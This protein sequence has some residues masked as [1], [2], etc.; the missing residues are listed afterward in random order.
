MQRQNDT[1]LQQFLEG[2]EKKQYAEIILFLNKRIEEDPQ[3]SDNYHYRGLVYLF[4]GNTEKAM[5]DLYQAISLSPQDAALRVSLGDLFNYENMREEALEE[6][7][8]AIQINPD[9][10]QA[11]VARAGLH[12]Q[13]KDP[14]ALDDLNEALKRNPNDAWAYHARG[15]YYL[16]MDEYEKACQD[17]TNALAFDKSNPDF[18]Q[19]MADAHY[20][21]H[22]IR[23]SLYR[24]HDVMEI[25][26][27][28]FSRYLWQGN[29]LF[30][31]G[32]FEKSKQSFKQIK[33]LETAKDQYICGMSY[34]DRAKIW[35]TLPEI[36]FLPKYDELFMQYGASYPLEILKLVSVRKKLFKAKDCFEKALQL[37]PTPSQTLFI[38][39]NL[40]G[41]NV[42]TSRIT[43]L[44][45]PHFDITQQ[46]KKWEAALQES[47]EAIELDSNFLPAYIMRCEIYKLKKDEN[48]VHQEEEL[49]QKLSKN[50]DKYDKQI[51]AKSLQPE[52]QRSSLLRFNFLSEQKN[53]SEPIRRVSENDPSNERNHRM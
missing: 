53:I 48:A 29:M 11:Y 30:A 16:M 27:D 28:N 42:M 40:S 43:S 45:D 14:Q 24:I 21:K 20:K 9:F 47:N 22:E 46:Q 37:G 15:Y 36:V 41:I 34:F 2:V 25:D 12:T 10:S 50:L 32:I 4:Q 3:D 39:Q 17:F 23:K 8:H 49:I 51:F 31:C 13:F 7:N 6:Y 52:N 1:P 33:P 5:A 44:I 35:L 19:S 26:K 38:H 18:L